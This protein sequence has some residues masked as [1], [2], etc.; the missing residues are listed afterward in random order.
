MLKDKWQDEILHNVDVP[1][2]LLQRLFFIHICST[3]PL[4]TNSYFRRFYCPYLCVFFPK[5]TFRQSNRPIII[6]FVNYIDF[7]PIAQQL[8]SFPQGRKTKGC[9]GNLRLQM[10]NGPRIRTNNKFLIRALA[11]LF[12]EAP[13]L[14]SFFSLFFIN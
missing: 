3:F 10:K 6:S 7:T 2:F 5:I 1:T 8:M 9:Y 13:K 4:E 14:V 11:S 12:F